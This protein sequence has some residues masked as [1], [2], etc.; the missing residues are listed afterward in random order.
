MAGKIERKVSPDP[1]ASAASLDFDP[2][3]SHQSSNM[4]KSKFKTF[5]FVFDF[6]YY[7][8]YFCIFNT[9]STFKMTNVSFLTEFLLFYIN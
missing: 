8:L 3:Y 9:L 6:N 4:G 7:L 5:F 1:V 2:D